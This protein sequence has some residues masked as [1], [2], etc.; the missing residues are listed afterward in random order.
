MYI[1]TF[2]AGDL[3][4]EKSPR[5]ALTGEKRRQEEDT[6]HTEEEQGEDVGH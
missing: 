4:A 1:L 2:L 6:E 5:P 3:P